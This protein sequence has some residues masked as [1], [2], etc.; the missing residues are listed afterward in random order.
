MDA[1]KAAMAHEG[2]GRGDLA[3][4][5]GQPRA[6]EILQRKRALTLPMIVRSRPLGTCRKGAGERISLASPPADGAREMRAGVSPGW[7]AAIPSFG[8]PRRRYG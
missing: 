3:K 2:L 1:I 6:T 4:V 7:A 5:I 8:G